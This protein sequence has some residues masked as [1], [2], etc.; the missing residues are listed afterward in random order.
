MATRA[1]AVG[2]LKFLR[3]SRGVVDAYVGGVLVGSLFRVRSPSVLGTS[4]TARPLGSDPVG[5]LTLAEAKVVLRFSDRAR[6][7]Y[8]EP[9]R[10]PAETVPG[11][12]EGRPLRQG[13]LPA[14][15]AEW[16]EEAST[17]SSPF[18]HFGP[19]TPT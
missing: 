4:W 12:S 2:A 15:S 6:A 16:S 17:G 13:P 3:R 11:P 18:D 10:S 14:R 5:D 7:L 9:G 1:S 8:P 19:R